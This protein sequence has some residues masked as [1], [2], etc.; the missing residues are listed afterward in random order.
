MKS[1][2]TSVFV[3]DQE[4][5]LRFYTDALGRLGENVRGAGFCIEPNAGH[6]VSQKSAEVVQ[7][8]R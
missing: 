2:L 8:T 3:D 7:R 4:K 1:H 5:A 6:E